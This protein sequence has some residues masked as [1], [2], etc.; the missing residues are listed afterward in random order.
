MDINE[1]YN[2][3]GVSKDISDDD[4]KREY[5]K[6]AAAYHPDRFKDD[7]NK[8]KHI[9]EAYQLVNDYRANPEKYNPSHFGGFGGGGGFNINLSDIL[10]G[11]G[12]TH[13]SGV[14]IKAD[15]IHLHASIS[16]KDHVLGLDKELAFK[17]NIKCDTCNGKGKAAIG[18]GCQACDGFGRVLKHQGNMVMQMG[19]N[20]CQGKNVRHKDCDRCSSK[21]FL[22]VDANVKIHIPSASQGVLRMQG[23]GNYAGSNGIFGDAYTDAFLNVEVIPDP[24]LTLVGADVV[25]TVKISMLE[26][27]E[28]CDKTVRT[29][30]GTRQINIPIRARNKD[31]IRLDG[32]GV[33]QANGAQRVILDIPWEED[34]EGLKGYLRGS[35]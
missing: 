5:K 7:P 19:C 28:G 34:I 11:F 10:G 25:S 17:K 6:L 20:R 1:A 2:L 26:A 3:L 12:R 8:F 13:E 9:N 32:C 24:D 15:P 18:N 27:L 23:S 16:F 31:E 30:Y 4:L 29:I 21:G 14:Q 33:K 22:T 35:K